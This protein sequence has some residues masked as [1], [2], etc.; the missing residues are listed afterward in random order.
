MKSILIQFLDATILNHLQNLVQW[1]EPALRVLLAVS[2]A[3]YHASTVE[4][5]TMILQPA[6]G[7]RT[8]MLTQHLS[9]YPFFAVGLHSFAHCCHN[10]RFQYLVAHSYVILVMVTP[11]RPVSGS[12][13][14]ITAENSRW[15]L[16]P[17][18]AFLI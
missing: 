7:Q 6:S 12:G 15:S 13:S 17:R 5:L 4:H 18:V 14:P 11:Q 1:I 8:D 3:P 16:V 10:L 9:R 2:V